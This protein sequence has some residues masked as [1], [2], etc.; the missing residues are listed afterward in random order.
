MIRR[1]TPEEAPRYTLLL[2]L[3]SSL[4]P[5]RCYRFVNNIRNF[6][7][8]VDYCRG[9][10]YSLTSIHSIAENN[11][12]RV[13]SE[14][15]FEKTHHN[16]YIGLYSPSKNINNWVY[17]DGSAYDFTN[18]NKGEPSGSRW[19][20]AFRISDGKWITVSNSASIPFVCSAASNNTSPANT[21]VA[22]MTTTSSGV[23]CPGCTQVITDD[24]YWREGEGAQLCGGDNMAVILQ[25]V[26][27]PPTITPIPNSDPCSETIM[28]DPAR[29]DAFI[30]ITYIIGFGF[31]CDGETLLIICAR[32]SVSIG[33]NTSP[34]SV[35]AFL[36]GDTAC[37]LGSCSGESVSFGATTAFFFSFILFIALYSCI[38]YDDGEGAAGRL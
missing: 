15:V 34:S 29:Y 18:W 19:Y 26:H 32:L 28:C 4:T 33:V 13:Q 25:R 5:N 1:P 16:F 9:I 21:T 2:L 35:E 38:A 12:L 23:V 37:G 10:G 27:G 11:F 20:V 30:A 31:N 22:S 7:S 36:I 8:A 6:T 3:D 24:A 14:N 17:V